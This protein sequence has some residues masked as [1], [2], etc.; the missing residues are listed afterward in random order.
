MFHSAFF[1]GVA[2]GLRRFDRLLLAIETSD[3]E[4]LHNDSLV[5][6]L[7]KVLI[8]A[9]ELNPQDD[10]AVVLCVADRSRWTENARHF[11]TVLIVELSVVLEWNSSCAVKQLR[12][13]FLDAVGLRVANPYS[14]QAGCRDSMFFGREHD[15]RH[16]LG[17]PKVSFAVVGPRRIGKTSLLQRLRLEL[18]RYPG[19]HY[20]YVNCSGISRF[21]DL[22]DTLLRRIS[23]RH[24]FRW[25]NTN[26]V[27]SELVRA[28]TTHKARY[29]IALDEF[30]G[31]ARASQEEFGRIK[32]W[33]T[34][35]FRGRLRFVVAGYGALWDSIENRESY[36]FNV[37]M[38][39]TLGPLRTREAEQFLR[40][41]LGELDIPIVSSPQAISLLL[42]YT[43][44]QP[45]L[46]Q[47]FCSRLVGHYAS[48]FQD[49]PVLVVNSIAD[50]SDIA[51]IVFQATAMNCSPLGNVIL[52]CVAS[53]KAN[54]ELSLIEAFR[55][56]G[57]R[58]AVETMIKETRL[59]QAAGAIRRSDDC[60][61]LT[62]GLLLRHI[63]AFWSFEKSV[64]AFKQTGHPSFAKEHPEIVS[65]ATSYGR[66]ARLSPSVEV[67]YSYSHKDEQLRDQLNA[68]LIVLKRQ[69]VIDDWHDRRISAGQEWEGRIHE[70]VNSAKVILLLISSD[71]LA[72]DY[73]YD[74]EMARA[75][76]RHYSGEAIVIPVILRA[77][78]WTSAPFGKLQALPR[79]AEPVTSW[80]NIDEAF[81]GVAKGIREAINN[82]KAS[83]G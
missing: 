10:T 20:L 73:C 44:L 29:L 39:I 6:A 74:I 28:A 43:G 79:N 58:V 14:W 80:Q 41:T 55:N 16:I 2:F 19:Q 49:D 83:N 51:E 23:G 21:H 11:P 4:T 68:H 64:Q 30:D 66:N 50:S 81:T 78:D 46:M 32:D 56:A 7:L 24:H 8:A 36:L 70:H 31:V 67:F 60:I 45:W 9:E 38:P 59:L 77:C 3:G 63:N 75:L 15:L 5:D 27:E 52:A 61:Q 33:F 48:S 37:F 17:S 12:T 22:A 71:F 1:S 54:N 18:V 25:Q 62:S 40:Q 47:V 53:E 69:H 13:A 72:S 65:R 76:E 26:D 34:G 42:N 35:R 82:L 57:I